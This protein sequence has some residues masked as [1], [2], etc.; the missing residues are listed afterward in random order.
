MYRYDAVRCSSE[1][2]IAIV[3]SQVTGRI[4]GGEIAI[5]NGSETTGKRKTA[6]AYATTATGT[7]DVRW[8]DPRTLVTSSDDGSLYKWFWHG[9]GTLEMISAQQLIEHDDAVASI[10]VAT[11]L[12][13]ISGSFDKTIK[14]WDLVDDGTSSTRTFRGHTAQINCVT[15]SRRA[16][17]LSCSEDGWWA[18]GMREVMPPHQA[19]AAPLMANLF[20]L[21]RRRKDTGLCMAQKQAKLFFWMKGISVNLA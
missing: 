6:V 3:G 21:Q 13:C 19:C 5:Y 4:W 10:D 12:Q 9:D 8:L 20:P 1:T 2:K 14:L 16:T 18:F 17:F 15:W 11:D 7:T